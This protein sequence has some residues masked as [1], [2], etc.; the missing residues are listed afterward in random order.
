M[1]TKLELEFE[2]QDK[3]VKAAQKLA[4]DTAVAKNVRKQRR[5]SYHKALQKVGSLW[6]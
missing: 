6:L 4:Q 3:I 1:L 5:Q 2:L